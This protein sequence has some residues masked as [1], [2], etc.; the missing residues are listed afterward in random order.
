MTERATKRPEKFQ[1]P[2][3]WTSEPPPEP[4]KSDDDEELSPTRYGD[5]V[6]DGI[7][8]DF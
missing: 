7:A 6:K 5:W 1:K 8:I 3:H 4:K 2:A